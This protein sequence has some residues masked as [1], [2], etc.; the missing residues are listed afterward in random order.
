MSSTYS[1][2]HTDGLAL[3]FVNFEHAAA[4]VDEQPVNSKLAELFLA[5]IISPF[6]E[7]PVVSSIAHGRV[8]IY[9]GW[10]FTESFNSDN[11]NPR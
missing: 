8:R 4:W 7:G 6:D 10:T 5:F 3:H 11:P 2:I 1:I 9:G